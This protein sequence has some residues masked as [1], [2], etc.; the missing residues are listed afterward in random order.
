MLTELEAAQFTT[1]AMFEANPQ[2]NVLFDRNFKVLDCNP[3]AIR[4]MG[5]DTKEAML[6]GFIERIR[7]GIPE[8]QPD[9]HVSFSLQDRLI[10]VTQQ[11]HIKFE[12]EFYVQGV[13][14]S[15]II[16]L[17]KILMQLYYL[18]SNNAEE[19]KLVI[20]KYQIENLEI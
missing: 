19:L 4:F 15:L 13:K 5:F 1:S 8:R 20:Q 16:D 3:A 7:K 12:T 14:K 18:V 2:V 6:A 9:G 10:A 11:G 17:K